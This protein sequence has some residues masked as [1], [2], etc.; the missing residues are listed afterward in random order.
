METIDNI[1]TRI[2]LKFHF[3]A[4]STVICL[5]RKVWYGWKTTAYTWPSNNKNETCDS[6]ISYLFW[7]ERGSGSERQ[8]GERLMSKCSIE[9][10]Q[11]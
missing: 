4:F 7:K 1:T 9:F 10:K 6:I 5:Q 11:P 2:K 3:P 8:I